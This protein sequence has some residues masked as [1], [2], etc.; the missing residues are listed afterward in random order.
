MTA[1]AARYAPCSTIRWYFDGAAATPQQTGALEDARWALAALATETGLTF[2][3]TEDAA[4][5]QLTIRMEDMGAPNPAGLGG[6]TGGKGS[7]R[8]NTRS[9]WA[10]DEW[11]GS[12]AL[13]VK[14]WQE[15]PVTW[16]STRPA[17]G[18]LFVHE[19]MHALGFDHVDPAVAGLQ[20]MNPSITRGGFGRGDLDG[21]HTM[22]L[23]QPCTV[24]P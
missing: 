13:K 4:K 11:G 3:Q 24:T 9:D 14:Q 20:I 18:W 10:N 15:G 21:L 17:R 5:S 12:E 6:W 7:V 23:N 2:E 8:I 16:T 1:G 19:I 22:Y